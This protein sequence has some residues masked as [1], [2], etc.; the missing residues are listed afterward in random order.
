MLAKSF[1]DRDTRRQTV[2]DGGFL[3][4]GNGVDLGFIGIGQVED[5]A[6]VI[7]GD[8]PRGVARRQAIVHR[9]YHGL[10]GADEEMHT[11]IASTVLS[12]RIQ[13]LR[14]CLRTRGANFI[15]SC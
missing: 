4:P 15:V 12:V 8:Q 13:F 1:W 14:R 3:H 7:A 6:H 9:V 2:D 5:Q 11:A 10:Q